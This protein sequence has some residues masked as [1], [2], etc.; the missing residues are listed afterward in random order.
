MKLLR[1]ATVAAAAAFVVLAPTAAHA[2]TA[3]RYDAVGDVMGYAYDEETEEETLVLAPERK[4]GDISKVKA[5]FEGETIRVSASF[6]GLVKA[7]PFQFHSL[8]LLTSKTQRSV[9]IYAFPNLWAGESELTTMSGSTVKCTG[10]AHRIDYTAKLVVVSVPRSCLA[11]S[12]VKPGA[13]RVGWITGTVGVE[14]TMFLDD[15]F[16]ST[17]MTDEEPPALSAKIYR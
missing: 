6:R 5:T 4:Q 13:V 11:V 2:D 12:G 15:G 9:D 1:T 10:L 16:R 3:T 14:D 7:G 17:P 8:Q